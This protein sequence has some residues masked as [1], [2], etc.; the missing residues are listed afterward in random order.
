MHRHTHTCV[1]NIQVI[2]CKGAGRPRRLHVS[3]SVEVTAAILRMAKRGM[4]RLSFIRFGHSNITGI[5][6]EHFDSGCPVRIHKPLTHWPAGRLWKVLIT[7]LFRRSFKSK[8]HQ[9]ALPTDRQETVCSDTFRLQW[10][11]CN[12]VALGL[13]SGPQSHWRDVVVLRKITHLSYQLNHFRKQ[14]I[15]TISAGVVS[16]RWTS[17]LNIFVWKPNNYSKLEIMY[18]DQPY[19]WSLNDRK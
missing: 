16:T 14:L 17:F 15:K 12:K 19:C 18:S 13:I 1:L 6:R 5:F 8:I 9:V 3:A 11:S 7:N 10:S 4:T 2:H